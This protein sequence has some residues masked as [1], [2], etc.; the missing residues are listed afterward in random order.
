MRKDVEIRHTF[1]LTRSLTVGE[2]FVNTR[3]CYDSEISF[4][5]GDIFVN[6]AHFLKSSLG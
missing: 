2:S 1:I 6:R 3:D 4:S 5:R